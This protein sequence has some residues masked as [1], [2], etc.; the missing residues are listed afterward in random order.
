MDAVGLDICLAASKSMCIDLPEF[1]TTM[2]QAGKLGKKSGSGIYKYSNSGKVIKPKVDHKYKIPTEIAE[3]IILRLVNECAACLREGIVKDA[4]L[5]DSGLIFGA[6][7][8][9]FRGGPMQYAAD[10]SKENIKARLAKLAS[11]Y[12]ERF[13]PDPWWSK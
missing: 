3:R 7:F 1:V 10:E 8:A 4:D 6:G 12:G 9:P 11:V 5:V 13:A 2:V